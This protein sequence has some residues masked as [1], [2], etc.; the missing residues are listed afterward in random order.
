LSSPGEKH[1]VVQRFGWYLDA[2]ANMRPSQLLHRPR[3]L[4]PPRLLAAPAF[5]ESKGWTPAAKG[6]AVDLAPQSGPTPAPHTTNTFTA[7]GA[8]R[9]FPTPRFWHSREE[10]LLFLFHLHGFADLAAYAAGPRTTDGD[11]FWSQVIDD[12]LLRC[13]SPRSPAWHPF[14]MSGRIMAWCAALS[15]DGWDERL[16]GRMRDSL[17]V[18]A[19]VLRRGVER[20]IG[21]NH[22]LRNAVALVFVGVCLDDARMT[23][24]ALRMLNRELGAQVLAD[25]GHEERSTA[26][27]RAVVAELQD[28][29]SLLRQGHRPAESWLD[30][31]VVQM[32]RWLAAVAG[33]D[34]RLPLLN[35]A[36]E[37]PAVER[38]AQNA[39]I[40]L[41]DTGYLA[42]RADGLQA[43]LDLA[44]VAPRHLPPHAHAD[45]LSFVLW[46]DGRP[47][48]VDPGVL[49]YSGP[50]RAW[51]R[52]TR[53]HNT[54]E[55]DGL[56]QC[57]FW[58]PFRAAHMPKVR[59]LRFDRRGEVV[60][61]SAE[62]DG[63]RRL[64]D[65]V[66]HRRTFAWIPDA[67]LLAID[68]LISTE[69]HETA[70]FL[71]LA[72]GAE[73]R[74]GQID[75]M[76]MLALGGEPDI[77][78]EV[79]R[80]APFLGTVEPAQTLVRRRRVQ[81][82]VPWG[83]ALLRAGCKASLQENILRVERPGGA[84]L[85]LAVD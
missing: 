20:D 61:V 46:A 55:V 40:D 47:V 54:V 66:V 73:F 70:S 11:R 17:V 48:V 74:D 45:V 43:V 4:I 77:T 68:R 56:D 51:F 16:R 27:H 64:S 22:V 31:T 81:P 25:G 62:H 9:T 5:R 38:R 13:S 37:G 14:P 42:L 78:V 60:V 18:H 6:L 21:G 50:D 36:W 1:P 26:Y 57:E 3:R 75:R 69:A 80:Y 28:V 2:A 44:P 7:V 15:A 82:G 67:G 32:Q 41:S 52:S 63:Y 23:D 34:G 83:W 49:S 85:E 29:Q 53:A 65:P 8:S 58:G 76:R 30:E 24:K 10:G 39:L 35:D 79:G 71:H 59:R 12:W 84:A 33:P 19:R 72:P